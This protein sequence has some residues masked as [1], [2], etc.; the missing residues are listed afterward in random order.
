MDARLTRDEIS[1]IAVG[2]ATVPATIIGTA[3]GLTG[4]AAWL[5]VFVSALVVERIA[6]IFV[7]RSFRETPWPTFGV[8][9]IVGGAGLLV[10]WI[11]ARLGSDSTNFNS[12]LAAAWL[13]VCIS[14]SFVVAVRLSLRHEPRG[15]DRE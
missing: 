13:A 8:W 6:A 7:K 2:V 1:A 9:L 5:L 14:M 10:W 12:P 3:F 15:P 11:G 4:V